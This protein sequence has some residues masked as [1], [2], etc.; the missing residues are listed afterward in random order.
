MFI[1]D[2]QNNICCKLWKSK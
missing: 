1:Y 2:D